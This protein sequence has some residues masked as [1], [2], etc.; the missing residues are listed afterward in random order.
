MSRRLRMV[1][2]VFTAWSFVLVPSGCG[3]GPSGSPA[4]T[5]WPRF[6]FD[7]SNSLHNVADST[8]TPENVADLTVTWRRD[9]SAV[10]ATPIVVGGAVYYGDWSG[11]VRS[12]DL[13]DGQTLW[14]SEVSD[15]AI[16]STAAVTED[17]VIVGDLAGQLHALSRED[18]SPVWSTSVS[19]AGASLFGS[20]TVF[21]DSVLIA[22]T[23]SELVPDDPTF[24]AAFV[25]VELADG[26][27]RWRLNTK[28]DPD[29]PYWVSMWSTASYDATRSVVYVGTGSTNQVGSGGPG[30]PSE[31]AP[32]DLPLSDGVLALDHSTGEVIWFAQVVANDDRRDFDVGAGPNLLT[33]DGRDVVGAGAKSGEYVLLDRDTGDELWRAMLTEGSALGG[34][35]S[36]AAT[37]GQKIYVASNDGGGPGSVFALAAATGEVVWERPF[38]SP[39]IGSMS[40]ANGVIFRGAFDGTFN[41]IDAS[42]GTVLWTAEV[43]GPIAGGAAVASGVVLVGYGSGSPGDLDDTPGGIVA[44]RHS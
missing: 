44:Y 15:A 32:V 31:R 27:E 34:I 39:I 38:G 20:P 19:S 7:E 42:D 16:S 28:P 8:I 26:S 23:D 22:M 4:E 36:T 30:S 2:A 6:G 37:D 3:S 10:T 9:D 25:A 11:V 5:S 12:V 41:A 29:S 17:F 18:G 40:L 13:R 24:D 43:D 21:E 33:V 35:M 14:E 1:L